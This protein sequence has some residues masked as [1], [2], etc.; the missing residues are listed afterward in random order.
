MNYVM[1]RIKGKHSETKRVR[2]LKIF[3]WNEDDAK[4]QALESGLESCASIEI[5][6]FEEPTQNQLDYARDLGIRLPTD[7]TKDDVSA[8]ID[9]KINEDEEYN[10]GLLEFATNRRV[11]V[12]KYTTS[13]DLYG[14]IFHK[15][16][17][18]DRIAF[19]SYAIYRDITRDE[20]SNLDTHPSKQKFYD[21]AVSKEH[22]EQFIKSF[23]RYRSGN[24][25][26]YFG[27]VTIID[28]TGNW[29]STAGSV[30][31]I[32]YKAVRQYLINEGLISES[33]P[34]RKKT[35]HKSHVTPVNTRTPPLSKGKGCGSVAILLLAI[36]LI[37][38]GMYLL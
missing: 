20:H 11:Y 38:S 28:H 23:N 31:T 18:V 12:S 16:P 4:K 29:T 5:I 30:D 35:I 32:A 10:H 36:S 14:F 19:F 9:R 13:S 26:E 17:L 22:D 27:E 24:E 7:A 21:F 2:T 6:P 8:L 33:M 1:Y 37:F 25:I 34:Y 3:A 15:L